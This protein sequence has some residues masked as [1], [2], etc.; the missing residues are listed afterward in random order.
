MIKKK[1][2]TNKRYMTIKS[3]NTFIKDRKK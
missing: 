1:Q 2:D 3:T